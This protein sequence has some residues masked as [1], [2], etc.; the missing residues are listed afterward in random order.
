[1]AFKGSGVQ[2]PSS[3]PSFSFVERYIFNLTL[4]NKTCS[5]Y[6]QREEFTPNFVHTMTHTL[7]PSTCGI[8]EKLILFLRVRVIF[9]SIIYI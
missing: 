4:N 6:I 3:P 1:M 9:T 8:S 5:G 2:I 7:K